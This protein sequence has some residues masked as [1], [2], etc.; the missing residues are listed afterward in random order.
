MLDEVNRPNFPERALAK[1]EREVVEIGDHIRSR[2]N[3]PI[4]PNRA[5]ILFDA[6]ADIE[7]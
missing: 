1:W 6:A 7:D 2:V 5:G 4:Y 3:V